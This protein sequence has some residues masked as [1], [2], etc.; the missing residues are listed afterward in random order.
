[1]KNT[2]CKIVVYPLIIIFFSI[3]GCSK[4]NLNQKDKKVLLVFCGITMVNP[5][6]EI[7]KKIEKDYN[8]KIEILQG[9][10]EDIYQ[11]LKMSKKG[12]LYFPGSDSYRKKHLSEGLL[13]DFMFVGYNQLSMIVAKGNPKNIDADI[14][15]LLNP[16][17][18]VSIGNA[19]S[20]SVGK[21]TKK[22]LKIAGIYEK[23]LLNATKIASDSRTMNNLLKEGAA[24]IILNWRAT[25]N[26][27]ENKD[28]MEALI[29]DE[30]IAPKKKLMI[31]LTTC[32]KNIEIAKAFMLYAGSQEG[33][34]IF[35]K[36]GF[37]DEIIED[38]KF[39][40]L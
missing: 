34:K 15:N 17:Y 5:I 3:V 36:Y 35:Y 26:F 38:R 27:P 25:A 9:G 32:S 31:N 8:C 30:S 23:V 39:N 13:S 21:Q 29:L 33:Q 1:M 10:S 40:E 12:D 20:S 16:K 24:D 2:A 14:K 7:A 6:K 19:E 22:V 28:I 18:L 11:S 4:E 37:L